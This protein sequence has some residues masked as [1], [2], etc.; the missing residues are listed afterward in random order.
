MKNSLSIVGFIY[1]LGALGLNLITLINIFNFSLTKIC[2]N[3]IFTIILLYLTLLHE[4]ESRGLSI[5]YF[6]HKFLDDGYNKDGV[7]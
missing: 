4:S 6:I 5:N 3:I 1:Y 7:W 2:A